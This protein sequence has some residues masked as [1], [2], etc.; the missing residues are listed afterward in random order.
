[1]NKYRERTQEKRDWFSVC[2]CRKCPLPILI[3]VRNVSN[4]F[5]GTQCHSL[6]NMMIPGFPSCNAKVFYGYK[7]QFNIILSGQAHFVVQGH[8]FV[9][10]RRR[11][12]PKYAVNKRD[13]V[14]YPCSFH[15]F[16]AS[17][18]RWTLAC[19]SSQVKF[20]QIHIVMKQLYK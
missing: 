3:K 15:P 14:N 9:M 5:S 6:E 18:I 2:R 17:I 16:A 13:V 19:N 4:P 8:I 20:P 11:K 1:M 12:V 7:T 10:S